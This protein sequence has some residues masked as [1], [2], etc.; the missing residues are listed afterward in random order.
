MSEIPFKKLLYIHY[1][2]F[3][4]LSKGQLNITILQ[5]FSMCNAFSRLGIKV[6]LYMEGNDDFHE[7]VKDLEESAFKE[8][9]LFTV[10]SWG[11][12]L[13]NR[14]LNRFL[15]RRRIRDIIKLEQP[16]V[17][18]TRESAFLN[19]ILKTNTPVIFEAHNIKQHTR[20]TIVSRY[21]EKVILKTSKNSNFICLFS[22]SDALSKQWK[23]LGVE[24]NKLFAWH[25][26]F[27]VDLFTEKI[28][29]PEARKDLELPVNKTIVTYTGGLYFDR[30]I[31]N[32]VELAGNFPDVTFLIIGGP[33]ENRL[34]F[35]DMAE[36]K[37]I[38]NIIF[39]GLINHSKIPE[40][41]Y[42]SD[43]LLALWSKKVPTINYCSPLKLF[44]YMA[45]GTLILAHAFPT[46]REVLIDNK[47]AILCR[48]DSFDD[49]KEKLTE[50][51]T[52][53]PNSDIGARAR[54]KAF[55]K[56]TWDIRAHK[57]IAFLKDIYPN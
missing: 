1:N 57:L 18:F 37:G 3:F 35:Q 44:E 27:D 31:E 22:I 48:P 24:E 19:P 5:V 28:D 17:V 15:I 49:L 42:A 9:L 10:L 33:E 12:I 41:L 8:K 51:I 6:T 56:Y 32:I 4:P 7:R 54:E 52:V 50:A 29:K 53:F 36:K 16:D 38:P 46:I 30:E 25:D 2:S 40:Y 39:K 11:K 55:E 20:Y 14:L 13:D 43:V 34:F 26:G 23:D 45:S 21:L 47:D